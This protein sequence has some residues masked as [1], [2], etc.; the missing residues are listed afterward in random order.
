MKH[1]PGQDLVW[2][3][4]FSTSFCFLRQ[5]KFSFC[6]LL[7][8]VPLMFNFAPSQLTPS[9]IFK[10]ACQPLPCLGNW[11]EHWQP[12]VKIL[13]FQFITYFVASFWKVNAEAKNLFGDSTIHYLG[14]EKSNSLRGSTEVVNIHYLGQIQN[15]GQN[16]DL[17]LFRFDFTEQQVQP[18]RKRCLMPWVRGCPPG[19]C[20]EL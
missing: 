16:T 5:W 2:S 11:S 9:P 8:I 4:N 12:P 20:L 13:P 1:I 10:P 14:Q 7:S 19:V 17:V 3:F 6:P 18:G 15:L